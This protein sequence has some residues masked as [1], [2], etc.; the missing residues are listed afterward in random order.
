MHFFY[1]NPPKSC[2]PT[3]PNMTSTNVNKIRMSSNI[4]RELRRLYT[5]TLIPGIELI[6]L[7]GLRILMTL[8]A[9][10]LDV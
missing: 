6:V 3:V 1:K 10:T 9:D 8:I 5:S 2:V 4:G 7:S